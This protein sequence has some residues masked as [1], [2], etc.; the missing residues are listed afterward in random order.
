MTFFTKIHHFTGVEKCVF[1]GKKS[2]LRLKWPWIRQIRNPFLT[3]IPK[4]NIKNALE[5]VLVVQFWK[6]AFCHACKMGDFCEK[7]SFFMLWGWVGARSSSVTRFSRYS[8]GQCAIAAR[9]FRKLQKNLLNSLKRH[10]KETSSSWS[11]SF[12]L[13][14]VVRAA[15]SF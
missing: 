10:K 7:K 5:H 3:L 1:W 2:K 13:A 15:L 11:C 8:R 4:I 14:K 9:Q 6:N 12:L